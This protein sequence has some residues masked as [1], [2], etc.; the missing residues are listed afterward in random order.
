MAMTDE[1]IERYSRHIILKE[2]GA[3]G[4]K[5]L[6]N[7]KVLIIGAGGL[8]AP[9]A[10]YLAAAGV[11]TIGIVDADEVDLS[12]LQR[13]IIHSTADIG[14]PKVKSAKE[15]MNAMNP[16][17]EVKTYH[18]FVDSTNIREL[19]REY[20]FIIDG[21]DNF[22]AKFLINDA[23]VMEK[24]PFSHAGI[25]RFKGQLMTYVPGEGPCYRCVFKNPPPKDAVPT[26]KQAGVIGAMG[27]VIGSLQAMEAVK[28]IVGVGK[29]LTGYLLTYDAVNQEF[30]KVKLPSDNSGC[31][32]CGA[33]PT[34]T[35]LID[36]EQE[37]CEETAG[38]F[39]TKENQ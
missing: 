37:V 36:Y 33:H 6:L 13:Q 32:V 27:G 22:P 1:Q 28:Y 31:A 25:I 15:T 18:M 8:G 2:V 30:R 5:K 20:D 9:A 21:T 7:A 3:K 39:E 19:V 14:K 35:E 23:C 10:M 4:Q 34:I 17:V 29:L 16:D 38:R 11:G 12:N 24:K 26:C